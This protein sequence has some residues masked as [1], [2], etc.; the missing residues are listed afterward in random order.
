MQ[1]DISEI[2][3]K[4]NEGRP[5]YS[6]GPTVLKEVRM[7]ILHYSMQ[8]AAK[9]LKKQKLSKENPLTFN[10]R[11]M[12]HN[13]LIK[14]LQEIGPQSS[15]LGDERPLTTIKIS[16]FILNHAHVNHS[17]NDNV[18]NNDNDN[19]NNNNQNH[20]K[21]QLNENDETNAKKSNYLIATG[22]TGGN[23]VLWDEYGNK[24]KE[25]HGHNDRITGV[26][27]R[28]TGNQINSVSKQNEFMLLTASAD[29]TAVLW[30]FNGKQ[31]MR[32][33]NVHTARLGI[34]VTFFLFF[35]LYF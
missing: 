4:I 8:N 18:N 31:L 13:K 15:E 10:Q 3:D 22:S 6:R 9:R 19:D 7:K 28:P 21:S 14:K 33:Q 24:Q 17:Y 25:F 29:R 20:A 1:I 2:A 23:I 26:A 12:E 27:F 11:Q 30:D 16:P 35:M 32:L 34:F 5:Y